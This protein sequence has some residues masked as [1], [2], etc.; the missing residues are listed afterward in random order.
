MKNRRFRTLLASIMVI[1]LMLGSV[2]VSAEEKDKITS[3]NMDITL[4]EDAKTLK[5]NETVMF[6][7]TY[8]TELKDMVFHLYAD[9]YGSFD[10]M[11][12]FSSMQE[13]MELA[14]EQIGDIDIEKVL[15][16]DKE[17]KFSED[18][19]ILKFSLENPLKRSEEVKISICFT[20]KIPRSNCRFGYNEGVYFIDNWYPI[21]S[22]YDTKTNKWDENPFHPVGE[23]NYS[24]VANYDVT[25]NTNKDIVTASTGVLTSEN[26][27]DA[28][29]TI[30]IKAEKVRDFVFMMSKDYKVVSKEVDGIKINSFYIASNNPS[31]DTKAQAERLLDVVADSVDFFSDTFGKYPYPELDIVE[32][33]VSGVAMEYPQLIQMGKYPPSATMGNMGGFAPWLE[34]AAVHETGHQWWYVSVGNNEYKEPFLDESLTVYSTALYYENRNGEYSNSG[35][36]ASIRSRS[37]P[38]ELFSSANSTVNDFKDFGSYVSTIYGKAPIIFEDLREQVGKEKFL[39]IMQTY[40]NRYLFKNATIEGF[41]DVVGEIAPAAVKDNIKKAITS[42][43]Y[44]PTHLQPTEQQRM[45]MQK[46]ML[47]SELKEREKR[48][49]LSIGS[50]MLK[51]IEGEDILIV[52]PA[53]LSPQEKEIVEGMINTTKARLEQQYNAKITVK[54][55]KNITESDIKNN[56]L[57]L[58]GNQINNRIISEMSHFFP[59]SITSKGI[60]MDDIILRGDKNSGMFIMKQ[61]ENPD[62]LV[63]VTFWQN[64]SPMYNSFEWGNQTQFV[65]RTEKGME[66]RGNF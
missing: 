65:I 47:K 19:Q 51:A 34:T 53:K 17:V 60:M 30:K 43:D 16:N 58:V 26:I 27:K 31:Q 3:Y 36:L 4:N 11:P 46:E 59:M 1:I 48:M 56:H 62:K 20:V 41:L 9:S 18:K 14:K 52:K 6:T 61:P 38:S 13:K 45:I 35:V 49:G 50:F 54:E 15:V 25:I 57:M 23:S 63:L 42:K 22:I 33:Y 55:D 44:N 40:F 66:L 29:K 24:D 21:I 8:D 39:K 7:N 5:V 64:T 10:T 2:T 12:K 32:T 37:F 28:D